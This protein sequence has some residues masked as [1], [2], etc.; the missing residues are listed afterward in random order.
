MLLQRTANQHFYLKPLSG[1]MNY[2]LKNFTVKNLAQ[3]IC[4]FFLSQFYIKFCLKQVS[5]ILLPFPTMYVKNYIFRKSCRQ[6]S[7][8]LNRYC[9]DNSRVSAQCFKLVSISCEALSILHYWN[10]ELQKLIT[11]QEAF[12]AFQDWTHPCTPST[13]WK[14]YF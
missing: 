2:Y 13:V 4:C 3:R 6:R 10:Q 7:I 9:T 5:H 8:H 11:S 12:S 1:G 14:D